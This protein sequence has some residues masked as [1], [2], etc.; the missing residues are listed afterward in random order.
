MVLLFELAEYLIIVQIDD[1]RGSVAVL[2]VNVTRCGRVQITGALLL[3][4]EHGT[5]ACHPL[6]RGA[7][8]FRCG[9]AGRSEHADD[10]METANAGMQTHFYS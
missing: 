2:A 5:G 4:H 6:V 9:A 10:E 7:G 8:G 1:A 3:F